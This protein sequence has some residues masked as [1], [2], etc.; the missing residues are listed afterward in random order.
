[1]YEV[2]DLYRLV[3]DHDIRSPG[4]GSMPASGIRRV[5][6]GLFDIVIMSFSAVSILACV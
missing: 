5:A 2:T 4:V 3:S 1:M 6:L